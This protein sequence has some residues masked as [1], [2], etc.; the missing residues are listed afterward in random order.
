MFS[1]SQL[2]TNGVPE[3]VKCDREFNKAEFAKF[4][5]LGN[6]RMIS[7]AANAHEVNGAVERANRSTRSHF[8][9][10]REF[11]Q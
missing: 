8:D 2:H 11:D 6:L 1:R 7:V 4:C 9:R 3:T 10:M 5:E